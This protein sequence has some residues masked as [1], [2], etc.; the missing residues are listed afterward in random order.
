[1]AWGAET[2]MGWD[3]SQLLNTEGERWWKMP[4]KGLVSRCT[5][6]DEPWGCASMKQRARTWSTLGAMHKNNDSI[7][8]ILRV[9]PTGGS[10]KC[11]AEGS[12]VWCCMS[13]IYVYVCA[14]VCVCVF[15]KHFPTCPHSQPSVWDRYLHYG[16]PFHTPPPPSSLWTWYICWQRGWLSCLLTF[17]GRHQDNRGCVCPHPHAWVPTSSTCIAPTPPPQAWPAFP[18]PFL[19][20][21]LLAPHQHSLNSFWTNICWVHGK[22]K[23]EIRELSM[24]K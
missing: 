16:P 5:K 8:M 15:E 21:Q 13:V 23:Q 6:E 12:A 20:S 4:R 17:P 18:P 11:D 14:L 7:E 19:H 24:S 22:W 10:H 9:L 3:V 2:A 1:M